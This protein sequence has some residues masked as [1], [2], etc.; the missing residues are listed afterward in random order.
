MGHPVDFVISTCCAIWDLVILSCCVIL[1]FVF[2]HVVQYRNLYFIMLCITRIGDCT[3]LWNNSFSFIM[4]CNKYFISA[5]LCRISNCTMLCNTILL[6]ILCW[7][8]RV[9]ISSCFVILYLECFDCV[10]SLFYKQN[11]TEW[12]TEWL[13][14]LH[15]EILWIK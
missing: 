2:H 5:Q 12:L 3:M 8:H 6:I 14:N 9:I 15:L 1:Q 4:L 10:E 7:L 11:A 13:T